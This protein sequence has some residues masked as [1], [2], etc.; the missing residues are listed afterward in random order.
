HPSTMEMVKEA[1][2]EL[3]SRKGVSRQAIWGFILKK[4]PTVDA[5]KLKYLLRKALIKGLESGDLV[6]PVNSSV[7]G[8]QGRFKVRHLTSHFDSVLRL[9]VCLRH[10]F[11]NVKS[12]H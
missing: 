6:R 1:L 11:F 2:K 4:Y 8:A 12:G 10:F 3:N 7:T 5:V 9:V